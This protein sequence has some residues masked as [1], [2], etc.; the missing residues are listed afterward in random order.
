MIFGQP[1]RFLR[2]VYEFEIEVTD[3]VQAA[4]YNLQVG[5]DGDSGDLVAF[6]NTH[7]NERIASAIQEILSSALHEKGAEAGFRWMSSSLLHRP[8]D[9]SGQHP[10][11]PLP[12]MPAR[13]DDGSFPGRD[14]DG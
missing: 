14:Q 4:A 3:P 2:F 10:A 11:M 1:R 8:V 6:G 13:D 12:A 7:P 5:A 9:D